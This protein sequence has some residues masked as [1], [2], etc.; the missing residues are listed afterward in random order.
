MWADRLIQSSLAKNAMDG[1]F[2]TKEELDEMV[3]AWHEWGARDDAFY[4]LLHGQAICR[5]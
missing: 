5:V 2:A 4:A 3:K 1:G